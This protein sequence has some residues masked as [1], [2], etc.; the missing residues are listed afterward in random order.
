MAKN[1]FLKK[2]K[3]PIWKYPPTLKNLCATNPSL[4]MTFDPPDNPPYCTA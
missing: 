1:C 3:K 4:K 2:K